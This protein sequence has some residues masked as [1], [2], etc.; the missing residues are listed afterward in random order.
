MHV[1]LW[2]YNVH[3]DGGSEYIASLDSISSKIKVLVY[4]QRWC[5]CCIG[6]P[7]IIELDK[8]TN[9]AEEVGEY[10]VCKKVR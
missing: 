8:I 1:S 5:F 9:I 4:I 6:D 10:T 7:M 3:I 2:L